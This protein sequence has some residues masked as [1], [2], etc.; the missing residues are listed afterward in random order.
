MVGVPIVAKVDST[1][2]AW[3][4]WVTSS[5]VGRLDT[6]T[7]SS[8]LACLKYLVLQYRGMFAALPT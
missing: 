4:R 2:F 7:M 1:L 6:K 8:R 3:L 5:Y